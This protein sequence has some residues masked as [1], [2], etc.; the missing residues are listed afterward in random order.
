MILLYFPSACYKQLIAIISVRSEV[1]RPH[2]S[3]ERKWLS[4]DGLGES[5]G[6]S[7]IRVTCVV[8]PAAGYA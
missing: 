6:R 3:A 8:G 7:R 4:E 5:G 2:H 1:T